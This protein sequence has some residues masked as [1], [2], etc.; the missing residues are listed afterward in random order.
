MFFKLTCMPGKY[1]TVS[2]ITQTLMGGLLKAATAHGQATF[3]NSRRCY[4]PIC[5]RFFPSLPGEARCS[6]NCL[7]RMTAYLFPRNHLEGGI[8][9]GNA[10]ELNQ[11]NFQS[12]AL[13]CKQISLPF[14]SLFLRHAVFT[15]NKN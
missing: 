11:C 7:P 3:K 2:K 8:S 10:T 5:P 4:V 13:D 15:R 6:V 9:Q 14:A 12:Q 1:D